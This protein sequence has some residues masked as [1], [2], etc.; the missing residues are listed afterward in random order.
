MD[1]INT[2]G[3]IGPWAWV[4]AGAVLLA[5]ELAL[6][7][8]V[9]I[10]MGVAAVVTG[11][12]R[13]VWVIDWPMQVLLFGALSLVLIIVWMK[14]FKRRERPS[15][16]PF[17]NNR[18]ASYIGHEAVLN[19]PIRDGWGRLALDDTVWRVTGPDLPAGRKVRV[20]AA[21]GAV[22]SVEAVV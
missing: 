4:I 6:P 19:E 8:G 9:L 20:T 18:A 15:D 12:A 5:L 11:L 10:W 22:L 17:L 14:F 1:I 2:I 3:S 13:F 16:R 7:G 21:S